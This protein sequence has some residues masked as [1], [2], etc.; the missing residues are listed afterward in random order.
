[1]EQSEKE[2]I[3]DMAKH[4][5]LTQDRA[6]EV[7]DNVRQKFRNGKQIAGVL[8][9]N[10]EGCEWFFAEGAWQR[11]NANGKRMMVCPSRHGSPYVAIRFNHDGEWF[12]SERFHE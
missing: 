5:P 2:A 10:F 3:A 4:Y 12:T 7:Y 6:Y 11:E 9:E 1:M 8:P